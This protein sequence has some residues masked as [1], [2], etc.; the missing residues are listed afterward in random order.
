M[1]VLVVEDE[2]KAARQLQLG[3]ED[4]GFEVELARTGEQGLRA[5]G[6]ATFDVA[7]VDV[8]LPGFSGLELVRAMRERGHQLPVLVLSALDST[9]DRVRG[10]DEGADDYLTKPY[11]FP[12][13]LAR[14]RALL[15]RIGGAAEPDEPVHLVE[16]VWDASARCITRDGHRIELSE[17]EYAVAELLLQ[18]RGEP[19]TRSQIAR[20][21]WD[22]DFEPSANA[23]EVLVRRL[24]LK[25]D[26][27]FAT[28]LI[29]TIRG[30]GYVLEA[31][32]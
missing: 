13:L 17:R 21:V 29:H 15:R 3:L 7:V 23:V 11:A 4:A 28:R 22:L 27:P 30:V 6:S 24:R 31:R 12:E 26:D 10:L 9:S 18:R 5:I 2:T 32:E 16:L 1:R 8:M 14:V 25:L 20:H 19:V